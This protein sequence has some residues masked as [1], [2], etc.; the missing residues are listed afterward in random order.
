MGPKPGAEAARRIAA[1][2]R[3]MV[4]SSSE[5]MLIVSDYGRILMVNALTEKL[6]V[7]AVRQLGLYWL[8]LNEDPVPN[9]R[10][11]A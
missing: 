1:R 9:S 3:A 10:G 8:V 6:F 5:A 11:G 2:I 4:E 7:E